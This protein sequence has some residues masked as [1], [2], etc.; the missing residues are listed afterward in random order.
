VWADALK[1]DHDIPEVLAPPAGFAGATAYGTL[2][3]VGPDAAAHANPNA[4]LIGP[5]L[6]SR[7]LGDAGSVRADIAR[8]CAALSV[9]LPRLWYS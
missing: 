1:L 8:A 9:R 7:M 3:Y 2:V 6:L 4:T 5:M